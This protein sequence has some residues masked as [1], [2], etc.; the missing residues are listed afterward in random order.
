[1]VNVANGL[2]DRGYFVDLVVADAVGTYRKDVSPAVR[3]VDLHASRVSLSLFPLMK[4]LWQERPGVLLSALNYANVIAVLACKLARVK[5]RVIVSDHSM[6]SSSLSAARLKRASPVKWLMRKTYPWADGIVAVSSGVADDLAQEIGIPRHRVSVVHNPVITDR[7]YDLAAQPVAHPWFLPGQPPVIIGVGRLTAAKDFPTLI[8]AFGILKKNRSARLV[9]LGDGELRPE[10]EKLVAEL[11]LEND[12]Q[13]P[14][15]LEN[16]YSWMRSSSLFV[17]SSAW[18]GFGN[19]LVEAMACGTPVVSTDCPGGPAEILAQGRWGR[20]VPV[21]DATALASAMR[22]TLDDA[23]H[24]A[25]SLRAAEFGVAQ[26]V[27]GYL[28]AMGLDQ[29]C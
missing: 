28:R 2:A 9:I 14:G 16:P 29:S 4:Y 25:V 19:V 5:T 1:M 12:V 11:R 15:F 20:L 6:L 27:D 23:A 24:P 3:L 8:S 21:G 22:M 10:L 26:A 17:L 13:L 7:L 18:E